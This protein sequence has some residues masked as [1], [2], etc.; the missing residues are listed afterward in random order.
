MPLALATHQLQSLVQR[1]Q[2]ERVL[3]MSLT[4]KKQMINCGTDSLNHW[5]ILSSVLDMYRMYNLKELYIIG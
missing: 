1:L 4:L 5:V 3:N 2:Y